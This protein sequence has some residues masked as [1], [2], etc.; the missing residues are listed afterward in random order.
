MQ[1]TLVD[2]QAAAAGRLHDKSDIVCAA[3]DGLWSVVFHHLL[4]DA[5][6]VN[7]QD[8]E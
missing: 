7:A 3:A 4:A 6:G 1:Q 8:E 5:G 2:F